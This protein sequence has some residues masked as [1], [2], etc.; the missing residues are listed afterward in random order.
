MLSE[1]NINDCRTLREKLIDLLTG[2]PGKSFT[3]KE[4]CEILDIESEAEVYALIKQIARI[5][6]RKG[7]KVAFSKP[8]CR[9]CGFVMSKMDARKCPKCRSEWIEP[10]KFAVLR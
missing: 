9:K 2:N 8:V 3:A 5:L 4:I 7:A 6:R 10:A 1:H